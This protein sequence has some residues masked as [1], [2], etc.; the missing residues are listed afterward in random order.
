MS[1]VPVP[2]VHTS[3]PE[4]ITSPPTALRTSDHT[5]GFLTLNLRSE[6]GCEGGTG[7]DWSLLTQ[8]AGL[9][10]MQHLSVPRVLLEVLTVGLTA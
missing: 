1:R 6:A 9:G 2:H 5:P 10:H 8:E 7:M 4:K 3:L